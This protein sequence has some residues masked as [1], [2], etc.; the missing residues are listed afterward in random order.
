[1]G[2]ANL[3][4]L[5]GKNKSSRVVNMTLCRVNM[6]Y[7]IGGKTLI[8]KGPSPLKL[9]FDQLSQLTVCKTMNL[10]VLLIDSVF[11]NQA[12]LFN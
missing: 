7:K 11:S 4:G 9:F 2:K 1:M 5:V 10:M 12:W 3:M 6:P 8:E